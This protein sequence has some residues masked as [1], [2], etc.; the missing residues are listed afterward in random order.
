MS[1]DAKA[2]TDD[3]WLWKGVHDEPCDGFHEGSLVEVIESVEAC[4]RQTLRW[5]V[6]IYP[7]GTGLVGY[8]T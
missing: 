6:R 8:C 7:D 3:G 4:L 5:D 1:A 2:W